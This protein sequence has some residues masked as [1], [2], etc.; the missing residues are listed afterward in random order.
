MRSNGVPQALKQCF[1]CVR[2]GGRIVQ[3]GMF[4]AGDVTLDLARLVKRE[5]D[6]LGSFDSWMKSPTP[7][8]FSPQVPTSRQC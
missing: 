1:D 6:Y 8:T 3:V 4:P 7:S 2:P 5:V